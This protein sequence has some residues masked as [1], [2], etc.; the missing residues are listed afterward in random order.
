[1]SSF[2]LQEAC[3]KFQTSPS[4]INFL[5]ECDNSRGP[6][7]ERYTGIGE[8]SKSK[9]PNKKGRDGTVQL[10][11]SDCPGYY[12]KPILTLQ[13]KR[14]GSEVGRGMGKKKLEEN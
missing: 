10:R 14:Q 5:V 4:K 13:N 2:K 1:M 12:H 6:D 3:E 11:D 7:S 9:N 8:H